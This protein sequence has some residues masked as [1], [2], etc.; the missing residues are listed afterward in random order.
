[1]AQKIEIVI[2]EWLTRVDFLFQIERAR[3][4]LVV[5]AVEQYLDRTGI[6][7]LRGVTH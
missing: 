1:V 7:F 4:A 6:L 3:Q 2:L 5:E